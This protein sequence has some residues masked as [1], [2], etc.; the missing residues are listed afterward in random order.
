REQFV[1]IVA[2]TAP[3]EVRLHFGRADAHHADAVRTKLRLPALTDSAHRPFAAAVGSTTSGPLHAGCGRKVH[4]VAI[5]ARLHV[6]D[7]AIRDVDQAEHV[8]V[9]H[10]AHRV[11]I[12]RTDFPAIRIAGVVDQ[13]VDATHALVTER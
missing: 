2:A 13:H 7:D 4:D 8:H 1:R 11:Q 10:L 9:E 12:E 6:A 3:T 5:A